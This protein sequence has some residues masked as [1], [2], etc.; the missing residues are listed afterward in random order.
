LQD[1]SAAAGLQ[2]KLLGE[3]GPIHV[4]LPQVFLLQIIGYGVEGYLK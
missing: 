3:I 2:A 1:V 4:A